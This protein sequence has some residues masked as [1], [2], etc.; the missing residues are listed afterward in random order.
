MY[1]L[2]ASKILFGLMLLAS[3][4]FLSL[5]TFGKNFKF[6]L[7]LLIICISALSSAVIIYNQ[8]DI[9]KNTVPTIQNFHIPRIFICKLNLIIVIFKAEKPS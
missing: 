6:Y 2:G 8:K 5:A 7:G 1:F 9:Y 4:A 3:L